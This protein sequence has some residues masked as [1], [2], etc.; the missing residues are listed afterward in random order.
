MTDIRGGGGQRRDAVPVETIVLDI[1]STG[2]TTLITGVAG[3]HIEIVAMSIEEK[4]AD[5]TWKEEGVAL[6]GEVGKSEIYPPGPSESPWF[7]LADGNDF[8]I[9]VSAADS[10]TGWITFRRAIAD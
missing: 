2:V 6:S 1:T 3:E 7:R 4:K 8:E 10:I 5:W 9:D